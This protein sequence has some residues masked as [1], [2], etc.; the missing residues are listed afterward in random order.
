[1]MYMIDT[2]DTKMSQTAPEMTGGELAAAL[3]LEFRKMYKPLQKKGITISENEQMSA[4]EARQAIL[5]FQP[6]RKNRPDSVSQA[7]TSLCEQYGI[8]VESPSPQPSKINGSSPGKASRKKSADRQ[9]RRRYR[10]QPSPSQEPA[11]QKFRVDVTA[12][13]ML[14][15]AAMFICYDGFSAGF[16]VFKNYT[17][18]D[19]TELAQAMQ[20]FSENQIA[21]FGSLIGF[22][23]GIGIGVVAIGVVITYK[24]PGS[25]DEAMEVNTLKGVFFFYQIVLHGV[26]MPDKTLPMFVLAGGM[27][28]G[29]LGATIYL[30]N[31]FQNG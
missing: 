13:L 5:H 6:A 27:A 3:G 28:L 25:K 22:C 11:R 18:A 2:K 14:I 7:A 21:R 17:M 8:P 1:M 24:N 9:P 29:N 31:K 20:N 10:A 12:V 4:E 30:R 26:A 16:I 15:C 23:V 19:G